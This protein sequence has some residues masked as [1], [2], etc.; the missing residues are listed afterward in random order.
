MRKK[1][2]NR[3][4]LFCG[5]MISFFLLLVF[6]TYYSHVTYYKKLPLVVTVMP[7][8][9]ELYSNGR[10]LYK[11]PE[12]SVQKEEDTGK[13]FIYT[14]REYQDILGERYLVTKIL[15][16]VKERMNGNMVLV[17]GIVREE[18]VITETLS[19]LYEN[20]AVLRKGIE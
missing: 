12:Q 7:E 4:L 15:I 14:A 5:F 16:S 9:T 6:L 17:D 18:P 13:L 3:T 2:Q 20:Q 1:I 11:I 10:Y 8:R 19:S